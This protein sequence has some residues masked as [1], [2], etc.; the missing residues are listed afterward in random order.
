VATAG[1]AASLRSRVVSETPWARSALASGFLAFAVAAF[2]RGSLL[3]TEA[4]RELLQGLRL[5]AGLALLV[6][7]LRWPGRRSGAA[8]LLA[9]ALFLGAGVA[10]HLGYAAT[11]DLV[12]LAGAT[13]MAVALASVA[14]RSISARIAVTGALLVLSV[15]LVV[16]VA[17]SVTVAGNVEGEALGRYQARA[18]AEADAAV[19]QART[20]LGPAR[21]VAGALAAERT[22][23]LERVAGARSPAP[24]DAAELQEALMTLTDGQLLD[25]DDPVV[26]LAPSGAPLAAVPVDLATST[27]L[28]LAGDAV[29][30]ESLDAGAERQGVAVIADEAFAVASAPIVAQPVGSR[31]EVVGAV[32][33]AS[34]L[35]DTYL[36]V[37]GTGGEDLTFAL[38]TPTRVVARSGN[39]LGDEAVE[40]VAARVIGDGTGPPGRVED[41]FVAAAPVA[42]GDGRPVLSLVVAA[43]DEAATATQ[44]ALFRTLFLV[45]LAAA[46]TAV[47]LA[48]LVGERIGRGLARLTGAARQMQQG[49]LDTRVQVGSDDELG[50]LGD[51]FSSM[52]GSIGEMTGELRAVAAEEA[53]LRSRLEAVVAGMSEALLAIDHDGTVIEVNRAAET[54]LGI[55]RDEVLGGPAQVALSWRRDD[56]SASPLDRADLI[57]GEALAADLAVGG[58]TIPV[59]VTSGTLRAESGRDAGSVVVLRDVRR[60]REVEDLKSSILANIG[61]ELRT[62]L[63]PIKGYAG[64]LA[65]RRLDPERARR[66]AGEIIS[67]VDQL[68]RVL[69][70]LVTFATI[71]AG[72]LSVARV[73]TS[74]RE[75]AAGLRERWEPQMSDRHRLA[76]EVDD[77]LGPVPVDRALFDQAVDEIID[78][79]VKYS[80]DGGLVEV[81]FAAG[82][83]DDGGEFSEHGTA[84]EGVGSFD[85]GAMTVTVADR[86][87][88]IPADRLSELVGAFTQVDQSSTRR[89]NG[90]GLGL[91]CADRI[92]RAH[93]GRLAYASNERQGTVVSILI[94]VDG[95]DG[96]PA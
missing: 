34:R 79:A 69:R 29:V 73:E 18:S 10:T 95:A 54:L 1:L 35:D 31:Q 56:G 55:E 45:A 6:G 42:G 8:L 13:A 84:G 67:G 37:L 96:E 61:H 7:L 2:L 92:V 23:P 27:R 88:G 85:A 17:V 43:T 57:D 91:A 14:R 78:N 81:R 41:G 64:M 87:I 33:V 5:A 44:E 47:A 39:L 28:S 15:V 71:A 82:V 74:A 20:G 60:E 30:D 3:V 40:G 65:A 58:E 52:A 59:V 12:R 19:A 90:L 51:A 9:V 22:A 93:G 77:R 89:F 24:G 11:G 21:L 94:P 38:V 80:P 49:A 36:R 46:L 16:A 50:V 25:L 66:F 70:Q 63:T 76:V 83:G 4:D 68:E 72:H 32:V 86:G 62:P 48:A 53:A 26:V 75:L